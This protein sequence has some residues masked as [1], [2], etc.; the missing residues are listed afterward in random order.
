M[1][2]FIVKTSSDSVAMTPTSA[3]AA[4]AAI[5][6]SRCRLLDVSSYSLSP[7]GSMG[8]GAASLPELVP[9]CL[10]CCVIGVSC[11][12]SHIWNRS[13]MLA[14]VVSRMIGRV[15]VTPSSTVRSTTLG[16][17]F[18][19]LL[20]KR[21]IAACAVLSTFVLS[22]PQGPVLVTSELWLAFRSVSS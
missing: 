16:R 4:S 21:W 5:L 12:N 18:A 7:T 13:S 11:A 14:C 15:L 19:L 17:L 2:A 9:R 20:K 3:S 1:L 6:Q 8:G 22:V 10:P